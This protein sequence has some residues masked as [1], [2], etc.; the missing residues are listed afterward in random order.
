MYLTTTRPDLM[1][2][3]NLISRFMSSPTESH[4]FAAKRILR[5]LKGTIELG[6]HYKKMENTNVVPYTDIATLL[7]I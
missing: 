1:Y 2:G 3:V 4:W 5:Y 6:I 7:E